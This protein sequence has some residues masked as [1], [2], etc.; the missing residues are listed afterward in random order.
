V[1]EHV[2]AWPGMGQLAVSS[3]NQHD[4]SVIIGF[5]LMIAILV[6]LSNMVADVLYTVVDPRVRLK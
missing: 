5:A 2:F 3:V 4:Y 6:L 1:V